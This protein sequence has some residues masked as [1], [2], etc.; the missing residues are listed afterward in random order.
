LTQAYL[1]RI[2]QLEPK[3]KSYITVLED[4]ALQQ[5]HNAEAELNAKN[6]RGKLHGIPFGVKDLFDL[7]GVRTT[8]GSKFFGQTVAEVD[9]TI[10]M[11]LRNAGTTF[12]GKTN[13]HELAFGV[14]SDNA[15]YGKCRNP[16][17]TTRSPGG[18]SGGSGAALAAG[19]CIGAV[20]SDTRGSI[21]IPA[22]LC[23]TVGLKPTYGRVSLKGV[24]P[25]SWSL[26]HAGPMGRTV[27]DV[28]IILQT[29]AG[30]D[31]D[32][33]S[34]DMPVP[35]YFA[36][37]DDGIKDWTVGVPDDYFFRDA[38]AEIL[39]A[40]DD[41]IHVFENL[42]AKLK[43]V[44]LDFMRETV[45]TSKIVVS[46]DAA[47]F[48]RERIEK[49]PEKFDVNVL[50]R[51]RLGQTFTGIDYALARRSQATLTDR[52]KG[53][54]GVSTNDR[55]D[56]I[57]TPTTPIVAPRLDNPQELDQARASLARLTAPFN[58]TGVPALSMP[59]GFTSTGLPIGL[60][61]VSWH[62]EEVR[63]LQGAQAYEGATD[64]HLRKPII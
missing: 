12:L 29:I 33:Y 39:T 44:N 61:I 10:T 41:A 46:S 48:H 16:W 14:I 34:F 11:K 42:G 58:M 8:G 43:T 28:A 52:L 23:G 63:L 56:L 21:R 22:A 6:Y 30:Y 19:L 38:D 1:D 57:L 27:K 45:E 50:E 26:D 2:S 24:I 4:S 32:L 17:D 47:A 36:H 49:E 9:S 18:S 64:W 31:D 40:F 25:L 53:L 13:M 35:D 51:L 55:C 59:C 20:G 54:L 60:Q 37:I 15:H 5:A 7:A 62:W 3:L